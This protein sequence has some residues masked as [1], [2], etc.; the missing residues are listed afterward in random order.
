[1]CQKVVQT[2][3]QTF[4]CSTP[5]TSALFNFTR[6]MKMKPEQYFRVKLV[7]FS[8]LTTVASSG[9]WFLSYGFGKCNFQEVNGL[10]GTRVSE[11]NDY[12]LGTFS[13]SAAETSPCELI[14]D[15]VLITPFRIYTKDGQAARFVV[16]FQIDLLEG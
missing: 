1:M 9:L 7:Y 5:S 3:Q 10:T 4:H 11:N 13:D 6:V 2:Y 8:N 12:F 14:I 15:D 16:S